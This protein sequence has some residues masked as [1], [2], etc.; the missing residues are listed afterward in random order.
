MAVTK[1]GIPM[2][3]NILYDTELIFTIVTGL[4]ASGREVDLQDVLSYELSP[5]P[6]SLFHDSGEMRI[7]KSKSDLKNSTEVKVSARNLKMDCT[8]LDSSAVL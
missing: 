1:I 8:V 5:I 7:Y 3:P 2:G 4:Q 6:T